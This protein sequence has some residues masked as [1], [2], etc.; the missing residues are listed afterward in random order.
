MRL[1]ALRAPVPRPRPH[2]EDEL[3]KLE[4][5]LGQLER[6]EL[7]VAAATAVELADRRL[8][9]ELEDLRAR[10]AGTRRSIARPRVT[11]AE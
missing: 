2:A 11:D 5:V 3:R 10:V 1:A 4:V 8:R 7:Y 9:R 6:A